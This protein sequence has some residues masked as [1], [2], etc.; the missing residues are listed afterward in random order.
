MRKY[1]N[2]KIN[3]DQYISILNDLYSELEGISEE[4]KNS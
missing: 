3:E 2:F 1:D 4:I